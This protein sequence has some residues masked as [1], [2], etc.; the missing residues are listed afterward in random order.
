MNITIASPNGIARSI[1]ISANMQKHFSIPINHAH[2]ILQQI[3]SG[4][5]ATYFAGKENLNV[6]DFGANVGLVSLY[7]LPACKRLIMVEPTP[8]HAA[9]LMELHKSVE[10]GTNDV[11]HCNTALT[12]KSEKVV[13]ATGH[14]TENKV[15]SIGGYGNNKIEVQ[16]EPLEYYLDLMADVTDFIKVDIES[17]EMLALTSEQLE[18]SR[19]RVRMFFVEVHPGY[20][21]GLDENRAELINRFEDAGYKTDVIDYQTFT[22]TYE[23]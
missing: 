21:G 18:K 2:T 5:Y 10:P 3:N 15:T 8:S 7:V 12:G 13:F 6:I 11:I 23:I 4:M 14:S 16:G 19:G 20:N 9:L 22:A 17:G 1:E